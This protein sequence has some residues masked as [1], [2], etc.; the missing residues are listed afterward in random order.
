MVPRQS[1]IGFPRH[2]RIPRAA[3]AL[4][5]AAG[6]PAQVR[7]I[8]RGPAVALGVIA[9]VCCAR[10]AHA[11]P[12]GAQV[13]AGSATI[14]QNGATW[15]ITAGNGAIINYQSFD[16]AAPETVRFIQPD[17]TSRV[18]NRI[19]SE[20]PTRI[21]GTLLANGRVY[22]VNPAGVIFGQGAVVNVGGLVAA[23]AHLS[24][25]DFLA[26][27]D[28]F[29]GATGSVVNHG[30]I[31]ASG[32]T[33]T[34]PAVALVGRAV[35]NYGTIASP[36]G[37]VVLA[38]GDDVF[39]GTKGS[40]I[41]VRIDGAAH[42]AAEPAVSN[43]GSINAGSGSVTMAAGDIYGLAVVHTGATRARTISIDSGASGDA[44]VSGTLNA[45]SSIGTGGT[46]SVTGRNVALQHA[47]L[48]ADGATGGGTIHVGGGTQADRLAITERTANA[49]WIDADSTL[50]A[51]A[52]NAG[53]GGEISLYSRSSTRSAGTL[54]ARGAGP[55]MGGF[56]ETSGGWLSLSGTPDTSAASGRSGTWLIDPLDLDIV[57]TPTLN[58][59]SG[60]IFTPTGEPSTIFVGDL[61]AALMTN[62]VVEL[63]TEGTA[64]S[65][66]GRV[67][68]LTALDYDSIGL[69]AGLAKTLRVRAAGDIEFHD[70][71]LDSNPINAAE[72]LTLDLHTPGKVLIDADLRL[73]RGGLFTVAGAFD[74]TAAVI[75]SGAPGVH[76]DIAGAAN[77]GLITIA[78][79]N[80][81]ATSLDVQ[82]A[83]ITTRGIRSGGGLVRLDADQS[84][85]LNDLTVAQAGR[86]ELSAG[87]DLTINGELRSARIDASAGRDL[88]LD[89][90]LNTTTAPAE[91]VT[92][93]AGLIGGGRLTLGSVGGPTLLLNALAVDLAATAGPSG[94]G[95]TIAAPVDM[96]GAWSINA[97]AGTFALGTGVR[98]QQI[99]AAA[100]DFSIVADDIALSAGA[101]L[102]GNAAFSLRTFTSGQTLSLGAGSGL[103]LDLAEL[104]R[105][106]GFTTYHFDKSGQTGL[107]AVGGPARVRGTTTLSAGSAGVLVAAPLLVPN[108]DLT[109][110]GHML[111]GGLN[112]ELVARRVTITGAIDAAGAPASLLL[113][114]ADTVSVDGPIGAGSPLADFSVVAPGTFVLNGGLLRATGAVSFVAPVV[115]STSTTFDIGSLTFESTL[116]A[117]TASLDLIV[118]ADGD[119][120]FRTL[121]QTP[122]LRHVV[123]TSSL[124]TIALPGASFITTGDQFYSGSTQTGGAFTFEAGG[125]IRFFGRLLLG[126]DTMVRA[127]SARFDRV[128]SLPA[129][130]DLGSG[131][132]PLAGQPDPAA[133]NQPNPALAWLTVESP[134]LTEFRGALGTDTALRGL[135]TDAP[136]QTILAGDIRLAAPGSAIFGD[137]VRL[138]GDVTIDAAAVTFADTLDSSNPGAF[139][140]RFV[141]GRHVTFGRDVGATGALASL[142]TAAVEQTQIGGDVTTRGAQRFG[143]TSFIGAAGVR[144]LISQTGGIAFLG[145]LSEAPGGTLLRLTAPGLTELGA[146]GPVSLSGLTTDGG[147]VTRLAGSFSIANLADFDDAVE[148]S[149][150]ATL[151]AAAA[152]FRRTLDSAVPGAFTISL[153]ANDLEIRGDVGRA[154][155]LREFNLSGLAA[156]RIGGSVFTIGQ[157]RYGDLLLLGLTAE[158][159][160]A[161]QSAGLDFAGTLDA[162]AVGIN[163]VADAPGL[164]RFGAAIGATGALG[165]FSTDGLGQT[166][167]AAGLHT[168]GT[169][170]HRD[171]VTVLNALSFISDAGDFILLGDLALADST[172]ISAANI[173]QFGAIDTALGAAPVDLTFQS[174]GL[175]DLRGPIGT[176]RALRSISTDAPGTTQLRG[177]L[178]ATSG[179]TL[180]FGDAVVLAGDALLTAGTI[181]FRGTV[182][183]LTPGVGSLAFL[184]SGVVAFREDVGGTTSLA[185]LDTTGA[186]RTEFHG[187]TRVNGPITLGKVTLAGAPGDRV[188]ESLAGAFTL[189]GDLDAAD[190][191]IGLVV[192]G[193]GLA[194]FNSP[195]GATTRPL[196]LLRTGGPTLFRAPAFFL[197]GIRLEDDLAT[198]GGIT[199]D[200]G[201]G[202]FRVLGDTVIDGALTVAARDAT[203]GRVDS[204]GPANPGDLFVQAD[205]ITSFEDAIGALSPLRALRTDALGI[206]LLS[207]PL[208]FRSDGSVFFA[209]A[210]HLLADTTID[211]PSITF[212]STLDA[213][214]PG[215]QTLSVLNTAQLTFTGAVGSTAALRD[216]DASGVGLTRI[217]GDVFTIG[218][219]RYG[220]AT[221]F[222]PG[223]TRLLSI[224]AGDLHFAAA[225]DAEDD[226]LSLDALASGLIA[227]DGAV[228]A[229]GT[230]ASLHTRG[231]VLTRLGDSVFTSAS[232]VYDT[233]VR[234]TRSL[235]LDATATDRAGVGGSGD[236]LFSSTIDASGVL[237][238]RG[239]N[240]LLAQGADSFDAAAPADL[241]MLV[242]DRV[243]AS[244]GL[245]TRRALRSIYSDAPGRILVGNEVRTTG[246]GSIEL[247]DAV[248]LVGNTTF[249][250]PL[251]LLGSTLDSFVPGA[252]TLWFAGTS[253][254]E[255]RGDVGINGALT[256]WDLTSI[257]SLRI[258]GD[259]ATIGD[260]RYP[261]LWLI[262]NDRAQVFV[263][264]FGSLT[265]NGPV[266]GLGG[267]PILKAEAPG[268]TIFRSTVGV[269]GALGGLETDGVG[270]TIFEGDVRTAGHQ[271]HRDI[272]RTTRGL[273]F[274]AEGDAA[275]LRDLFL[276]GDTLINGVNV[277]FAA[278]V[279]SAVTPVRLRI[280]SPGVTEFTGSVGGR[281]PL[282]ELITDAAGSTRLRNT[283]RTTADGLLDFGD[284]VF[285]TDP[286]LLIAH[287]VRFRSTLDGINPA[288]GT[289]SFIG[290][291]RVDFA[292]DIG[293]LNALAV[294]DTTGAELGTFAGDVRVQNV[295]TY[296]VTRLVG[297]PGTRRFMSLD[298]PMIFTGAIDADAGVGLALSGPG[299]VT[300]AAD[301]GATDRLAS[302]TH[303]G[304]PMLLLGN[305][306]SAG[307]IALR[308]QTR[309]EGSRV[310][311]ASDTL[312]LDG[313]LAISGGLTL[314]AANAALRGTINSAEAAGAGSLF[315]E[316]GGLTRIDAPVGET[317]ALH[318]FRTD[319]A[320]STELRNSLFTTSA[321]SIFI[322]DPL[323]LDSSARA[324][325]TIRI[326]GGTLLLA[327]GVQNVVGAAPAN[328]ALF[329]TSEPS[330]DGSPI[331]LGGDLG[332]LANPLGRLT[333]GTSGGVVR[334]GVSATATVFFADGFDD[335]GRLV[336]DSLNAD[337]AFGIYADN[338]I[339][340][341]GQKITALGDLTIHATQD[342]WISDL[343]ALGDLTVKAKRI[344]VRAREAADVLNNADGREVDLGVDWVA[345]GVMDFSVAPTIEGSTL[346][347]PLDPKLVVGNITSSTPSGIID[348]ELRGFTYRQYDAPL[349]LATFLDLRPP[350]LAGDAQRPFALFLD[351]RAQGP[352]TERAVD[353]SVAIIPRLG[354]VRRVAQSVSISEAQRKQLERLGLMVNSLTPQRLREFFVGRSLYL[355]VPDTATPSVDK[356]SYVVTP[357][358]LWFESVSRALAQYEAVMSTGQRD[359]QDQLIYRDVEIQEALANAW[360]R[361]YDEG[362]EE[363][364]GFAAW[365]QASASRADTDARLVDDL[366]AIRDLC[367]QFAQIGL[368]EFETSLPISRLMQAIA[369]PALEP[370]QM[371][372][373][374]RAVTAAAAP[375]A[376]P[377]PVNQPGPAAPTQTT[378]QIP[379]VPAADPPPAVPVNQPIASR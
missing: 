242:S 198:I 354:E 272:T 13:A 189:N 179:G 324:D 10:T 120:S 191:S 50:S 353:S 164:T 366:A 31:S 285:L 205:G 193:P 59:S 101:R 276:G 36:A 217:G 367:D 287:L 286:T 39:V 115:L 111:V 24:D 135:T 158:Q 233:A 332:S 178:F 325:G 16:I 28:H 99:D 231:G 291:S 86:V 355:D 70:R 279:D 232:Q 151:I 379:P 321:G 326:E 107:L 275:F 17:A 263:S 53:A 237:T 361:Y 201:S 57:A 100:H 346:G 318:T 143:A 129:D 170:T 87:S 315:I 212:A 256:D 109:I 373:V 192:R 96:T 235:T 267:R 77:L 190:G 26:H 308:G 136:G 85:I 228:G 268:D 8:R 154:G 362:N 226:G 316:S 341:R 196:H 216:L 78:N 243:D 5:C 208:T 241:R 46:I 79:T 63:V 330:A 254:L 156:S 9:A 345:G 306:F 132:G 230:L 328:L 172:T 125:N 221:L 76:L 372:T 258:G 80:P 202:N 141:N 19:Q 333:L 245:G 348:P 142:D 146:G 280:D 118:A 161:S 257:A 182:D 294:L 304:G 356:Q 360:D 61:R 44:L 203:F 297:E 295:Q 215:A 246:T 119:I 159:R 150:D 90:G 337:A 147:G 319:A 376:A 252:S 54:T 283:F 218:T 72:G 251:V 92:L 342:A 184:N 45:D 14:Q 349:S 307:P 209:D 303:A 270:T 338:L 33:P 131:A 55:G 188:F 138:D 331:R 117:A 160:F 93:R 344:I 157:Q 148:L 371:Y 329:G 200:A 130:P 74:S 364:G 123:L 340:G 126:G 311:D 305:I 336:Y 225:L 65:G 262:G 219:Q 121:P 244:A 21:D 204:A 357:N 91:S 368:S 293:A 197:N 227:F 220:T 339:M 67:R 145:S 365:L 199:L 334:G 60:P 52:T 69:D 214:T 2:G 247:Y 49:L 68:F 177:P 6:W 133:G 187:N 352:T 113:R 105:L 128:D 234:T 313:P 310:L 15:T 255:V 32:A 370:D 95:I 269:T 166:A 169:Q 301:A 290:T 153:T 369:P 137:K 278:G 41:M 43:A 175:T 273:L 292:G 261:T 4:A 317:L 312:E 75:R 163:F 56:I 347:L 7:L 116:N 127:A 23:G 183:G 34:S 260:Q 64:G 343:S 250:S 168:S 73:G 289:L 296:G 22:L 210:V 378:T 122:I 27:R 327:R 358:R 165:T 62:S 83:D 139:G 82:A 58:L 88:L 274:S 194:S 206:T 162:L 186:S 167:F 124:G 181:D 374:V 40:R 351:L 20:A 171:A 1:Q 84:L 298:G 12:E 155:A 81:A 302:F 3:R 377:V 37:A 89:A 11:G 223:G 320:G 322:L 180:R 94:S 281:S 102:T 229:N 323:A 144:H 112:A 207:N 350:L 42:S 277:T 240:A 300:L 238:L 71:V 271:V 104:G 282:R 106:E 359:A 110:A 176:A 309:S 213:D 314:R 29:T 211:A 284:A 140:L 18:L 239:I 25:A 335:Q 114:A 152:L 266:G 149:A 38:A 222:G 98:V 248:S 134:G 35:A 288:S 236:L 48:S 103:V 97:G 264:R 253:D 299:L 66:T 51:N 185:A 224:Q 363:P 30:I 173:I 108:A 375:R 195:V 174:P 265:F 259:V 47:D 249:A